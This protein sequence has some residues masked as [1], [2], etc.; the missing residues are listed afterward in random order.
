MSPATS[1]PHNH[2]R[3]RQPKERATPRTGEVTHANIRDILPIR[4][5]AKRQLW[6]EQLMRQRQRQQSIPASSKSKR[7]NP[8]CPFG[9]LQEPTGFRK[10]H[11]L[12]R[13]ESKSKVRKPPWSL[14]P[15]L[16]LALQSFTCVCV[17]TL[18]ATEGRLIKWKRSNTPRFCAPTCENREEGGC[19]RHEDGVLTLAANSTLP[20]ALNVAR[21]LRSV[22]HTQSRG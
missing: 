3:Q 16:G 20:M 13:L 8:L 19:P 5:M 7:P 9:E 6:Q 17:C 2:I 10:C 21:R 14:F 12:W 11:F 4:T 1:T 15:R 18:V 22:L